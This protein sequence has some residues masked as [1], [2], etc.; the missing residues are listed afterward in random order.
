[1]FKKEIKKMRI[2]VNVNDDL[3]KQIDEYADMMGVSRSALC[4]TF[5]GQGVLGYNKSFKII[6]DLGQ[7]LGDSMLAAKTIKEVA[8]EITDK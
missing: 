3:V 7:K 2:Q 1:M 5:I 6:D 8:N 4:S